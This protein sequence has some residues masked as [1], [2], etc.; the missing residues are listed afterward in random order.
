[1][2]TE[3]ERKFLC[4]KT[5]LEALAML[6]ADGFVIEAMVIEQVYL[7]AAPRWGSRIRKIIQGSKTKYVLTLKSKIAGKK[8]SVTEIETSIT[9]IQYD[10]IEQIES[11]RPLVKQRWI[12][13]H[14]DFTNIVWFVDVFQDTSL[15]LLE[16]ELDS[17]D[18]CFKRY[19]FIGK[20]VT[21]KKR[22]SNAKI[23]QKLN[24]A[25]SA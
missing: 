5:P 10:A 16:V 15:V 24:D 25:P 3:I 21:G 12:A 14:P 2:T 6:K 17:E 7:R 19:P 4:R 23:F 13:R 11:K 22:Y 20:E 8:F 18:T 1:M 9:R